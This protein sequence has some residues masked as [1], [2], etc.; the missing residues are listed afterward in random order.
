M[1]E[2]GDH[3]GSTHRH[4][5]KQCVIALNAECR[6]GDHPGDF[7]VLLIISLETRKRKKKAWFIIYGYGEGHGNAGLKEMQSN[8]PY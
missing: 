1:M 7:L 4:V 6:S 2:G 5:Q 8:I 3:M